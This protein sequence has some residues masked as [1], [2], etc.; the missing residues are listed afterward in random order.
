MD[1][2]RQ[3]VAEKH[4]LFNQ[5]HNTLKKRM[6]MKYSVVTQISVK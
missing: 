3:T 1:L 2:A 5:T 4:T 6:E